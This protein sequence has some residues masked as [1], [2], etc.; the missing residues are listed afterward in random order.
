MFVDEKKNKA[1]KLSRLR[2]KITYAIFSE[3]DLRENKVHKNSL[4][5]L[6]IIIN[7]DFTIQTQPNQL[8]TSNNLKINKVVL[9]SG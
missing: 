4:Q 8:Q 3:R 2:F 7:L 1:F 6:Q 9:Q 5:S